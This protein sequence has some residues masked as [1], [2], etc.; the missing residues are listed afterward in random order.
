MTAIRGKVILVDDEAM[1]RQST[2]QWFKVSGFDVASY[3]SARQALSDID[4]GFAGVVV[5]D[6]RMPEIT[7]LELL[8]LIQDID[9]TIPVILLTAHGDVDMA[10]QALKDGA[11]DFM[12]K[13]FIPERLVEAV[14][15]ACQQ[16]QLVLENQRLSEAVINETGIDNKIIGISPAI[17][18]LKRNILKLAKLDTNV[19]IYGDTG[20][21][22]ELVAQCLHD[23]GKR[24]DKNFVPINC[25]AIPE[26]LIESELFG[27]EAGAFTGASKSRVGKFEY[28]SNG[29]L[30]LDEIE[31]MPVNLQIKLLRALQEGTIERLGANRSI[32]VNLR[33]IA[34]A[35][36]ELR[37]N[38][39][40][41][42]DLFY[43]L[44]VAELHIPPLKDRIEDVPLLFNHYL[45]L[46]SANYEQAPRTLSDH[47]LMTL[48]EYHWPGNVR[49][50]KN[51]AIRYS[52][53]EEVTVAD[54]LMIPSPA[55][56]KLLL[57]SYQGDKDNLSLALQV[58]QFEAEVIR[59]ALR[60]YQ[61]N[62]KATMAALDI[63][64]RTLN[65]KM[66]KYGLDRK[67]FK[68]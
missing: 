60:E 25:G 2:E 31:S 36:G 15:R 51:I 28:A 6:V 33:V 48:A 63:P 30:F 37:D 32:K 61:G 20:T 67:N 26:N 66:I 52:L 11:Y 56:D 1:V 9:K 38:E 8:Q 65:Q 43:R 4:E 58:A 40:F 62:I 14:D 27:H 3:A 19:I 10:I 21:G 35:K 50:L 5:T 13:P 18:R 64:R 24:E 34:A 16:R 68:N 59:N 45:R 46:A 12:E 7:G 49:E 55:S 47:D 23:Y 41:R 17:T 39:E 29:S 22:K 54:L 42:Q 53:D 57:D 44:N